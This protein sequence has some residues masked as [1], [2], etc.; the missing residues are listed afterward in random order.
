MIKKFFLSAALLCMVPSVFGM[1]DSFNHRMLNSSFDRCFSAISDRKNDIAMQIYKSEPFD[2]NEGL[3]YVLNWG[4]FYNAVFFV[5]NGASLDTCSKDGKNIHRLIVERLDNTF[6]VLIDCLKTSEHYSIYDTGDNDSM[7]VRVWNFLLFA[8][9]DNGLRLKTQEEFEQNFDKLKI[10]V[11]EFLNSPVDNN[12]VSNANEKINY[13]RRLNREER[14]KVCIDKLT[15]L[16]EILADIKKEEPKG[17]DED[18]FILL[19]DVM[20]MLNP[21]DGSAF[22]EPGDDIQVY[23]YNY[24]NWWNNKICEE[25]RVIRDLRA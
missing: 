2:I 21:N 24:I 22:V 23:F 5:L 18:I 9:C 17:S 25:F 3:T 6:R 1:E 10:K 12:N 13:Y 8:S 16:R 7:R 4:G 14:I 11:E 15:K 19:T 20:I